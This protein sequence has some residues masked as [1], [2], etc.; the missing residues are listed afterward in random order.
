MILT[1]STICLLVIIL[2]SGQIYF[3]SDDGYSSY[4]TQRVLG[5][6]IQPNRRDNSNT[7]VESLLSHSLFKIT[8]DVNR[9]AQ[10]G[11][12]NFV[13]GPITIIGVLALVLLAS[14]GQTY[15]ELVNFM[16]LNH[17]LNTENDNLE[18]HRQLGILSQKLLRH[19]GSS[20]F[21]SYK[22][23]IFAQED[24]PIRYEFQQAA[25]YFYQSDVVSLNFKSYPEVS[26][27]YIN[28]W[29]ANNTN[30]KIT[31]L[32]DSVPSTN[33][34]A[35][36]AGVL[37]FNGV[38][39]R[40]F[41]PGGTNWVPFY[42]NG[43]RSQSDRKV[44]MMYNGGEFPYYKDKN[45]NVE[46]LGLPYKGRSSTMYVILP[47]D[48]SIDKLK[49]LENYLTPTDLE[50]LVN[51]TRPTE[52]VLGLPKMKIVH[53]MNLVSTM[54][55]LGVNSLFNSRTANLALLTPGAKRGFALVP[56][57]SPPPRIRTTT[58]SNL[59]HELIFARFA[60]ENDCENVYDFY[61]SRVRCRDKQQ[62]QQQP[63]SQ[64]FLQTLRREYVKLKSNPSQGNPGIYA[65][66]FIHKIF[67]DVNE[68][69]TEAAAT[70]GIGISRSGKVTIKC[71]VPF[72]FFIYHEDTKMVLF[73]GSIKSPN[74]SVLNRT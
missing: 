22:T 40:P 28:S 33:T 67:I 34:K 71:D 29:I 4:T 41:I 2:C 12:S 24:Y 16:G 62:Q 30:N 13:F 54:Q 8:L 3:P 43:R 69:G 59:N 11:T 35:I 63:A 21:I 36:I 27:N 19:T 52:V 47:N 42:I 7:K 31:S 37:Y 61:T 39:E 25:N 73:W 68:M 48:S 20:Y 70:S 23:A 74:P 58:L 51:S 66:Q 9:A 72:L 15:N 38:W 60:E 57:P 18:V 6:G 10:T 49:Q 5:S 32:L 50:R 1:L 65:D 53:T 46:I 26:Y 64:D 14:V 55:Y 56:P 17:G 44:M 45:L